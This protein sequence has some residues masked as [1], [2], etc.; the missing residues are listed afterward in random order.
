VIELQDRTDTFVAAS[1]GGGPACPLALASTLADSRPRNV[2]LAKLPSKPVEY[3]LDGRPFVIR[4]AIWPFEHE[5][6]PPVMLLAA[7]AEGEAHLETAA[8]PHL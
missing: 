2:A 8:E 5:A 6:V 7:V 1:C 3:Q 4:E